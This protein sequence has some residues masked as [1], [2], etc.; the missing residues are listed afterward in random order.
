MTYLGI[1]RQT[2]RD[3]LD[4]VLVNL[5]LLIETVLGHLYT[6]PVVVAGLAEARPDG[7]HTF[8]LPVGPVTLL[9]HLL[10][11]L[12]AAVFVQQTHLQTAGR[13]IKPSHKHHQ[14]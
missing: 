14:Y 8:L 7:G 11:F 5:L 2:E 12:L 1:V 4:T 9:S 10:T 3:L 6:V 13:N